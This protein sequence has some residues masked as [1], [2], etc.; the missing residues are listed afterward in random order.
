[1]IAVTKSSAI[2]GLTQVNIMPSWCYTLV[3]R[4]QY[5][6][7]TVFQAGFDMQ[8][9]KEKWQPNPKLRY[10][11]KLAAAAKTGRKK[12]LKRHKSPLEKGKKRKKKEAS[13]ELTELEETE[14][15]EELKMPAS[16]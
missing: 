4:E 13:T 15:G 5:G 8:F 12:N 9:L 1:M 16:A 3:W 10:C 11:P 14:L 2:E 6:E 7:G